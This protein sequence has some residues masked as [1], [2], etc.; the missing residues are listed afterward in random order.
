MLIAAQPTRGVDVG[1]IEYIHQHVLQKRDEGVA[2]L[3]ISVELDEIMGLAD[4]IVV[5]FD[6]Q[7]MGE[8]NP[9]QTDEKELGML[10][11]G[12]TEPPSPRM[13]SLGQRG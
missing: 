11:A 1:S 5:M 3:L 8:R 10:M 7:I 4:R 6:G 12:I 9:N 2:V 13:P